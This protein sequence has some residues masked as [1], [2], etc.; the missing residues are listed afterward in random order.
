[1]RIKESYG[2]IEEEDIQAQDEGQENTR[3]STESKQI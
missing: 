2:S 3:E 1:V